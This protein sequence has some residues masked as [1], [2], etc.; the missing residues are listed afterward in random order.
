MDYSEIVEATA[1]KT[2]L[3]LNGIEKEFTLPKA[4]ELLSAQVRYYEED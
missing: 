2:K 4:V 1:P 3:L